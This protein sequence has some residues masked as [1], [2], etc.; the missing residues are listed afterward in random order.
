M[1]EMRD[2]GSRSAG[3]RS[4]A[5]RRWRRRL[6]DERAEAKVYLDLAARRCGEEREILLGPVRRDPRLIT[7]PLRLAG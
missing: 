6:A 2:D 4:S 5:V 1:N 3:V 7:A